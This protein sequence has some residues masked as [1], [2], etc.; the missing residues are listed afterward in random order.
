MV[1]LWCSLEK[2]VHRG[3]GWGQAGCGLRVGDIVGSVRFDLLVAASKL[4]DR[5]ASSAVRRSSA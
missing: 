2:L 5:L 1:T 4:S 3:W